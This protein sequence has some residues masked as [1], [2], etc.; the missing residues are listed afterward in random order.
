VRRHHV[1]ALTVVVA[2]VVLI[3]PWLPGTCHPDQ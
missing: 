2:V 3:L 1:I